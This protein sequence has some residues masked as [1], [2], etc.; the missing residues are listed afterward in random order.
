MK[1]ADEKI[2]A[3]FET[4]I[5]GR[6]PPPLRRLT[7]RTA[8]VVYAVGR[9]V[10]TGP[11]SLHA[12]GISYTTLVS[13]VPLLAL[14]FSVLKGLGADQELQ[15]LLLRML[16]PLGS[17]AESITAY[18]LDFV[19]KVDVG[20][21]GA[22]GLAFLSYT[23][24]SV[25]QKIE[26]AFNEVWRIDEERSWSRKFTDYLSVLM[27]GPM[28][29]VAGFGI[30]GSARERVAEEY[31]PDQTLI[32][33]LLEQALGFGPLVVLLLAFTALYALL[34]NTRVR[35]SA[36]FTGA[37]VAGFLWI[38]AGKIF[39]AFVATSASYTAI[40]AAFASM[41]LFLIWLQLSWLIVLIG[42]STT[43]YVQN[44][45]YLRI[46][47]P[48]AEFSARGRLR[49]GLAAIAL[50]VTRQYR[51]EAPLSATEIAARLEVPAAALGETLAA[52]VGAGL[53]IKSSDAPPRYVLM[54]P[55]EATP[56]QGV[57]D[58]I[59]RGGKRDGVGAGTIAVAGAAVPAIEAA[60]DR[61]LAASLAGRTLKDLVDATANDR[62]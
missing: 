47:G 60:I 30:I 1:I 40:Y 24:I 21:L 54:V 57:V 37:V 35:F 11:L 31:P 26:K 45:E 61:A 12:S 53:L 16:A 27:V 2:R 10:A 9:D 3:A 29:L 48:T 17:G 52:L 38:A 19:T 50:I 32:G 7:V 13:L 58:A 6:L 44:P 28:L 62:T 36:A 18:I 34:P 15:P 22:F 56:L 39:A 42:A 33:S 49:L 23:A 5:A 51:G 43:F 20:V 59:R 8:R 46:T 25:V 55:A 14:S 41:I 4:G